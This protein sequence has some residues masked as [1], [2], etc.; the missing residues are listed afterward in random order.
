MKT[1][2]LKHVIQS[3]GDIPTL[4]SVVARVMQVLSDP[5]SSASD[6][7]EIISVD[8]AMTFRILKMAN[9]AFY[10]F[11]RSVSSVTE[12]I[13]LLGFTTVRNLI[14]TT[15]MYNFDQLWKPR[16]KPWPAGSLGSFN[17]RQEWKHSVATAIMTRELVSGQQLSAQENLGFLAGLMHDVGKVLFY[18]Y[19]PK[20]YSAVLQQDSG[21]QRSLCQREEEAM[22]AHHGQIGAW[23]VD[24]W[25]L[26][27]EIVTPIACHHAPEEAKEQKTLTQLLY[28][29]N[30]LAHA[31]LQDASGNE[32]QRW[33]TQPGTIHIWE[34]LGLAP[35]QIQGMEQALLRELQEIE[36]FMQ[37]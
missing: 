11:P 36:K 14:L 37:V 15:M 23:M 2:Q 3:I 7:T 22:G 35:E 19:F 24:R 5:Y 6:L 29:A 16:E 9:S 17:Q 13:V 27:A 33:P 20:E 10:G 34:Q 18:H 1:N 21:D 28:M 31:T 32:A 4:P 8:Q 12:A 25:N 30:H 26:P